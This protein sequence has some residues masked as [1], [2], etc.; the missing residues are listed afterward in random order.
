MLYV[1][2]VPITCP[3][4]GR[5]CT[6]LQC[7]DLMTFLVFNEKCAGAAWKCGVCHKTI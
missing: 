7:F 6:H 1:R 4:R 3:G 2:Q 5:G